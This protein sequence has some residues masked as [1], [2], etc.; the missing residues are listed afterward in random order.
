MTSINDDG[1]SAPPRL[2]QQPESDPSPVV[3]NSPSL[4]NSPNGCSI[5]APWSSLRHANPTPVVKADPTQ[6]WASTSGYIFWPPETRR[7]TGVGSAIQCLHDEMVPFVQS[8]T[9]AHMFNLY[10]PVEVL[11][12]DYF[13]R[14]VVAHTD[15]SIA[16]R[17]VG[18][19]YK[20]PQ[21]LLAQ[22]DVLN[23][24]LILARA[25]YDFALLEA[26]DACAVLGGVELPIWPPNPSYTGCWIPPSPR[27]SAE[28]DES[29][30]LQ[31]RSRK[32]ERWG[33][34]LWCEVPRRLN[35]RYEA[36]PTG[37]PVAAY[38]MLE[39]RHQRRLAALTRRNP[40]VPMKKLRVA[41]GN[42]S[43][44][45]PFDPTSRPL[46]QSCETRRSIERA[47]SALVDP[48][49]QEAQTFDA[50]NKDM[51]RLLGTGVWNGRKHEF[52]HHHSHIHPGSKQRSRWLKVRDGVQDCGH[53]GALLAAVEIPNTW[54]EPRSYPL[55]FRG[56]DTGL[57][58]LCRPVELPQPG[59]PV[60][61]WYVVE[62]AGLEKSDEAKGKGVFDAY[63]SRG[64]LGYRWVLCKTQN[65]DE[66]GHSI[67]HSRYQV[68]LLF[69]SVQAQGEA[70]SSISQGFPE[71]LVNQSSCIG[72]DMA[73]INLFDLPI[74]WVYVAAMF[75]RPLL[76]SRRQEL[77]ALAPP[78]SVPPT[79]SDGVS[80]GE[81][82]DAERS[83]LRT[84]C[85]WELFEYDTKHPPA[86]QRAAAS[87]STSAPAS[88]S[89]SL[90]LPSVC[91]A[92][93]VSQLTLSDCS[94]SQSRRAQDMSQL[95]VERFTD[96]AFAPLPPDCRLS[97]DQALRFQRLALVLQACKRRAPFSS[98]VFPSDGAP[99][100][101]ILHYVASV[102][103]QS[104][105]VHG[106][107]FHSGEHRQ[108]IGPW[109]ETLKMKPDGKVEVF[110]DCDASL[111]SCPLP[112][113][114]E[115]NGYYDAC[116]REN[117]QT[118]SEK[119]RNRRHGANNALEA[120]SVD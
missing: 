89:T 104:S 90:S 7:L 15:S 57:G 85:H 76:A 78:A 44:S 12:P 46:P 42:R 18:G 45:R 63:R 8:M 79:R 59:V 68:E 60:M 82:A 73:W 20:T 97:D 55:D 61:D 50:F 2:S 80:H 53:T 77:L 114:D 54:Y 102:V 113:Q 119:R 9:R 100:R 103:K 81:R 72:M 3:Y 37:G 95:S 17:F 34:P 56:A 99:Y 65:K 38:P 40:P 71:L 64:A 115:V 32:L 36:G 83:H 120:L 11:A 49:S 87:T 67:R 91:A 118:R 74:D 93:S 84:L 13:L 5:Q 35:R 10:S 14:V 23:D 112:S 16:S 26:L 27:A 51:M 31:A 48:E 92:V 105:G 109:A 101:A 19:A 39:S 41:A 106:Y 117:P 86:V 62:V 96:L 4:R 98:R 21:E 94:V 110:I 107:V 28:V 70:A 30:F 47:I 22:V 88:T 75:N 116:N 108:K 29:Y 52:Q 66:S 69:K 1:I 24:R 33:V 43:A 111:N 25:M 58:A 6:V